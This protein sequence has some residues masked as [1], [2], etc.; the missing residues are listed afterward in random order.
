MRISFTLL[1]ALTALLSSGQEN[2]VE[3]PLEESTIKDSYSKIIYTDSIGAS[4]LYL[5]I[6]EWVATTYNS[7]QDV[8]QMADEDA[9]IIIVKAVAPYSYRRDT[10]FIKSDK[11]EGTVDYTLK[12][13]FK[14]NRFKMEVF[15]FVSDKYGELT[16]ENRPWRSDETIPDGNAGAFI[17]IMREE[18]HYNRKF[19]QEIAD[20]LFNSAEAA[21]ENATTNGLNSDDW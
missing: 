19:T 21:A 17:K 8:V 2:P 15:D 12:V 10:P 13:M 20:S 4:A 18:W 6:Y 3:L 7:A 11:I 16:E 5:T 14:E 1:F 9:G